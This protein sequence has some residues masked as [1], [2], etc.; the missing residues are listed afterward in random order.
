[1]ALIKNAYGNVDLLETAKETDKRLAALEAKAGITAPPV[2]GNKL[3]EAPKDW[4]PTLHPAKTEKPA[5]HTGP[6]TWTGKKA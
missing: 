5:L 6:E 2:A 1:M 3:P 4:K